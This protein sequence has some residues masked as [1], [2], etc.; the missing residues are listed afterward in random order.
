MEQEIDLVV[1]PRAEH[2]LK[3]SEAA[4]K[5]VYLRAWMKWAVDGSFEDCDD[6]LAGMGYNATIGEMPAGYSYAELLG[7]NPDAK[8]VLLLHPGGAENWAGALYAPAVEAEA[9][10]TGQGTRWGGCFPDSRA[11]FMSQFLQCCD[12]TVDLTDEQRLDT[13]I[14]EYK[15]EVRKVEAAVPPE[16]LLKYT[17]EDGWEPLCQFLGVDVPP[18]PFPNEL[19]NYEECT[20]KGFD[21]VHWEWQKV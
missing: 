8:V 17:I 4:S 11:E 1:T 19:L 5:R 6:Q 16:K 7:R 14:L 10:P 18:E 2:L 13:C 15:E 20:T 9:D 12:F 21:R 3:A